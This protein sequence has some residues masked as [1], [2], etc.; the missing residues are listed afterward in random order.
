MPD[1]FADFMDSIRE[2]P[3]EKRMDEFSEILTRVMSIVVS[4]IDDL[5]NRMATLENNMND[6]MTSTTNLTGTIATLTADINLLKNKIISGAVAAAPGAPSMPSAPGAAPLPPPPGPGAP[7]APPAPPAPPKP[8]P[9]AK[10][11]TGGSARSAINSELKALF[12]K[13]R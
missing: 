3:I 12:G 10:P 13:R 2:E 5:S 6:T 4:A 1:S 9:P 7:T 8:Q 11:L